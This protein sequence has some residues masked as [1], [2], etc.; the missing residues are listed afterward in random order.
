MSTRMRTIGLAVSAMALVLAVGVQAQVGDSGGVVNPNLAGADELFFTGTTGEV[1]PCVR[2][3]GGPVGD[4]RVGEV[5]RSL[6]DAF[7]ARV[8]SEVE[9]GV[10]AGR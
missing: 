8:A 4:G 9:A 10:G 3:D 5:T 1:R 2:V 7:L 6:S